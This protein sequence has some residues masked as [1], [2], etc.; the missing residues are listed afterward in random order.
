MSEFLVQEVEAALEALEAVEDPDGWPSD[1]WDAINIGDVPETLELRGEQVPV[2]LVVTSGGE[3]EGDEAYIVL[4]VGGR[5][6]RKDG[7]YAS[8]DGY[9]WDGDFREVHE[10]TRPVTFYE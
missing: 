7:Y 6:F 8:H 2:K 9:Y 10:V 1:I 4:D 3:G 5:L